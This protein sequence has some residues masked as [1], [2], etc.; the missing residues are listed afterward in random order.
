MGD[1]TYAIRSLARSRSFAIASVLTLAVG[2]GAAATIYSVINTVLFRPLPFPDSDRYVRLVEYTPTS[3]PARPIVERGLTYPEYLDWRTKPRTLDNITAVIGM[4]QRM[5]RTPEGAA[6]LWGGMTSADTFALMG[7]RPLLGRTLVA[8]DAANPDVVVLSHEVWQRHYH[9]DPD[10]I[11]KPLEFRT[12]ALLAPQPMR[13]LTVVGVLPADFEFPTQRFDFVIPI[14]VAPGARPPAVTTI[15]RLAD[16]ASLQAALDEINTIG[17]AMREPWPATGPQL[18]GRRRFELQSLKERVVAP[19]RPAFRV[20]MAT[21]VVVLLI[22]CANVANLMLARGSTQQREIAVRLALGARR[23]QIARQVLAEAAVLAAA[24]GILGSGVAAA[25]VSLVKQLATVD[26]PGIFRLMFGASVLPRTH[27]IAVNGTLLAIV[28]GISAIACLVFGALPALQLSRTGYQETMGSRGSGAGPAAARL[29]TALTVAQ[30]TLATVMLTGAGLLIHSFATLATFDKGYN[31]ANVLAF[32]LLFPDQYSTARKG[33]TIEALLQRF[34]ANP[35]VRSAGFARHGIL[36]GEELYIGQFVPP[37]KTRDDVSGIRTRSVSDGYLT[38]MAVPILDGREFS[39]SD[40]GDAPPVIVINRSAAK[41]F[42]G[43]GGAV[44]QT[45]DWHVGKASAQMKVVG[46]VED[47]RQEGATDP[48]VPEIFVEYRQYLRL[49]DADAPTRQNEGAIGFLSFA[50]RTGG[51]PVALVPQ[52][53]DTIRGIDPNIGID[54]IAPMEVLEAGARARERFYAVLLGVFAAAASLL[55]AIGVYGVLAYAVEQRTR[56]IGVRMALGAERR[57]VL[58]MVMRRGLAIAVTG[59]AAGLVIAAA[60][61]RS[62][63][64]LLF[65][66]KPLDLATFAAVAAGFALVAAAASYVPA[67]RATKVDPAVAL[68]YE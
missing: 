37:G 64:S 52:V 26:A 6:G 60:G 28:F 51:D 68:R 55:A 10:I 29:R 47:V 59:I 33:E 25:G 65:G 9:A 32:N 19:V 57:Q 49:M 18:D 14:Y 39:P 34:R 58:A 36:I 67:R 16:G 22:V 62:L 24:G 38:A 66:I 42:F 8:E 31:P 41:R 54:A 46:V 61:A 63:E 23:S 27:E 5:V 4:S 40:S 15:A 53:R 45:V 56:E 12:G 35:A 30:L 13:L 43:D 11:G 21:V 20:L 44:G 2:I 1:L 50:L 7:V 48:I 17:G 3:N